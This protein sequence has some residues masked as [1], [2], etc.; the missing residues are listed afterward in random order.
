MNKFNKKRLLFCSLF[1]FFLSFAFTLRL[2]YLQLLKHK[3]LAEQAKKQFLYFEQKEPLRGMILDRNGTIFVLSKEVDSCAAWPVIMKD[4]Q[5]TAEQTAH[6]LNLQEQELK[7]KFFSSRLFL[8]VKR[9]LDSGEAEKIRN[10][11]LSGVGLVKESKRFYP[12]NDLL[13]HLLGR[14][15]IDNQGI[16]GIE[17]AYDDLLRGKVIRES[18]E[19]DGQGRKIRKSINTPTEDE[20][21]KNI[22]LTI[23]KT[24]QHIAEREL[25][26]VYEQVQA[27]KAILLIQD[28]RTGEILAWVCRPIPGEDKWKHTPELLNNLVL[29]EVFE[30][31]STFKVFPAG[32]ALE[33]KLTSPQE[34]FFCENGVFQIHGMKIRDHEKRGTLTFTEVLGY[35][36]NIGMAKLGLRIDKEK[37]YP[38]LANFG[39]GRMSGLSL[40][41]ESPGIFLSEKYPQ[42]RSALSLP[43]LCFGQ[44]IGVTA[45]Q[46]LNA[47]SAVANGGLLMEPQILKEIRNEKGEIIWQAQPLVIRRVLSEKTT[48]VLTEIL[49]QA[50]EWGTGIKAK[51]KGYRIAGK[52]G[53]AQKF[54]FAKGEYS[55]TR[56]I[57]S[58]CGYF[59]L[60]NPR[61]AILV[62]FDEPQTSNYWGGMLAAPVF[63][64]IVEEMVRY[65]QIPPGEIETKY[66]KIK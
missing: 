32:F 38:H 52:T 53:T 48:Q 35:S 51:I 42:S 54:D 6:L 1:S 58:F 37:I 14:V 41:G 57:S 4:R 45:I 18:K 13:W 60:P 30:P 20:K 28:V 27:K 40:S 2:V 36:S 10:L 5:S 9:K 23:D 47:Y 15:N 66:A 55:D 34:K 65:F 29:S 43:I 33:E 3:I 26:K 50:V 24:I 25:T 62:I 64:R 17:L 31:G 49:E 46:I 21:P 56:H 44:G 7:S 63:A 12:E 8:W 11:N 16:S 59:P 19:R 61:W 22:V 39:F